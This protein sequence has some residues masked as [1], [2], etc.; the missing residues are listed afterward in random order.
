MLQKKWL[1]TLSDCILF[2]GMSPEDLNT[3]IG[4]FGPKVSSYRK[5]EFLTMAGEKIS[6]LGIILSGRATIT[7]ENAVGNRVIF[8]LL[9]PGEIFGEMGVFS[10]NKVWPTTIVAQEPSTVML[11]PPE[12][13][14][15]NCE[16]ACPNHK[17]LIMNMLRILSDKAFMLNRKVEYLTMNSLRGKVSTFLLEQYKK[18]NQATF[19]VPLKR[20]E[21]ADFL[22]VSRPSLSREMCRMRDEGII[23]FHRS[24]VKIMDLE[25]LKAIAED[26]D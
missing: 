10:A 21:L 4:C 3:L 9:G 23:E 11:L 7:K 17:L 25:A 19:I 24:S 22:N 15:G 14:V 18:S 16:R 5:N 2:Q 20:H 13:F 12:K 26:E 6:S 1:K 8:A